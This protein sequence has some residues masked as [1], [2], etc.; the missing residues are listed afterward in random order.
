MKLGII[1]ENLPFIFLIVVLGLIYF[2]PYL[3]ASATK[4]SGDWRL[5][6]QNTI[7][8]MDQ[9]LDE[10][11]TIPFWTSLVDSGMPFF[12]I[13]D[14]PFFY[15]PILLLLFFFGAV[16]SMNILLV[17]HL[18]L[19][20]FSMFLLGNY[21]FNNKYAALISSLI[22]MFS[23]SIVTAPPFWTYATAWVPLVALFLIKSFEEKDK[24]ILNSIITGVL[25]AM[26]LLSGGI[27][28]VY[29]TLIFFFGFFIFYKFLIAKNKINFLYKTFILML[30]ILAIFFGLSLVKLLPSIEWSS[31]TNRGIGL[32]IEDSKGHDISF[33]DILTIHFL[34]EGDG[35]YRLGI[36]GSIFMVL[37]FF[38][39][40]KEK[41]KKTL[42][43]IL[44][45]I[46]NLLFTSGFLYSLW[47]KII[48]ALS[49]Q[50]HIVRSLFI[51]TFSASILAGYGFIVI[52]NKI[53]KYNFK[54][55]IFIFTIIIC[56]ILFDLIVLSFIPKH[57]PDLEN[58]NEIIEKNEL[59]NYLQ[60]Q[61]KPFRFHV[62]HVRGI[63]HNDIEVATV[64]LKL[65]ETSQGF[66][67]FWFND[68]LHGFMSL[69]YYESYS[70]YAKVMGIINVKYIISAD[71]LNISGLEFMKEFEEYDRAHPDFTDGPYLYYNNQYIP[72]ASFSEKGILIIGSQEYSDNLIRTLILQKSFNASKFAIIRGDKPSIDDYS[73]KFLTNFDSIFLGDGQ[74]TEN[75]LESLKRYKRLGGKIF[76]DVLEGKNSISLEDINII[77]SDINGSL[78]EIKNIKFKQNSIKLNL[79]ETKSNILI[80]SERLT[81][82]P[83]WD[84][85]VDGS[86]SK[87]YRANGIISALIIDKDSKEVYCK[88]IPKYF[89]SGLVLFILTSFFIVG[90]ITHYI[91][92]KT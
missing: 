33:I 68:Y 41:E 37:S 12:A 89:I 5:S 76:P 44:L 21:L 13:P 17:L 45:M 59:V 35:A 9:A 64:P 67:A 10:Y 72:R 14:K 31:L 75:S 84:C 62:F 28:Q 19:A 88:Y 27:L 51:Y 91:I 39:F 6:H 26:I 80:L 81:L 92:K 86:I 70:H 52:Y 23:T 7:V 50:R 78:N 74:I 83:G 69:A 38:Y 71:K 40:Y 47:W 87:I 63:D 65:E 58:F 36:T 79:N 3:S 57:Y 15:P 85:Y 30:I 25:L 73:L 11:R 24:K 2:H 55:F 16:F 54:K 60:K 46:I 29:F 8:I 43:F 82:F 4:H 20:G 53:K 66:G 49:Q 77:F 61:E 32:S 18:I 34:G 48:P 22:F 56:L 90:Y 42:F 1:K